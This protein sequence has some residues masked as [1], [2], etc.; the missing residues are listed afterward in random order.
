MYRSVEIVLTTEQ[1]IYCEITDQTIVS[2]NV[3]KFDDDPRN[4]VPVT[5]LRKILFH[6]EL[7]TSELLLPGRFLS[8]GF[9]E[10]VANVEMRGLSDVIGSASIYVQ[11]VQTPWLEAAVTAGSFY[12]VPYGFEVN[13]LSVM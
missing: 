11:A 5:G 7:S 9:Y 13:R 8:Y 2:W 12:T 4:S 10:I 6:T 1:E 3:Y